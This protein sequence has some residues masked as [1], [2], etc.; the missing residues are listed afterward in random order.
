MVWCG[1]WWFAVV[2]SILMDRLCCVVKTCKGTIKV[3]EYIH[4]TRVIFQSVRVCTLQS[5]TKP[6]AKV[7][8]Q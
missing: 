2:C 8:A 6:R 7:C 4:F 1:L 3:S 5:F